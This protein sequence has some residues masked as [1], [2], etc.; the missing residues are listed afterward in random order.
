MP[1]TATLSMNHHYNRRL[2][3]LL[4]CETASSAYNP[5]GALGPFLVLFAKRNS[6]FRL[7]ARFAGFLFATFFLLVTFF[8]TLLTAFLTL[9]FAGFLFATFLFFAAIKLTP[10][11][12]LISICNLKLIMKSIPQ[13]KS[14]FIYSSQTS[15]SAKSPRYT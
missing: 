13:T 4:Y 9:F 14:V 7:E 10:H 5:K 6:Y 1:S 3:A 15:K 11:Y 8:T 2:Q 12:L